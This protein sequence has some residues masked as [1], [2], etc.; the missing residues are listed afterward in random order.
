MERNDS[1]YNWQSPPLVSHSPYQYPTQAM[2]SAASVDALSTALARPRKRRN[3]GAW[4]AAI[5]T[6]VLSLGIGFAA[7]TV[8]TETP[9]SCL[10]ALGHADEIRAQASELAGHYATLADLSSSAVEAAASWD[11]SSLEAITADLE[12]LNGDMEDLTDRVEVTVAAYESAA[13]SCRA[14]GGEVQ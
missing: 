2:P 14:A 10:E 7:G 12:T 13:E 6:T 8:T 9:A 1:N 3:A 4:V 11:T 5:A